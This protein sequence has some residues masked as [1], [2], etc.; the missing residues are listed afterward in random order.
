MGYFTGYIG[1]YHTA[2]SYGIYRFSLDTRN[3]GLSAPEPFLPVHGSKY[4]ALREDGL[5]ASIVQHEQGAGLF[6]TKLQDGTHEQ[7]ELLP[8]TGA[9]SLRHMPIPPI[10]TAV[11]FAAIGWLI[12][13][14]CSSIPSPSHLKQ[15][16]TRFCC[17]MTCFLSPVWSLTRSAC[18]Q[19]R[20][21]RRRGQSP[22]LPAVGRGTAYSAGRTKTCMLQRK[23]KIRS[24]VLGFMQALL[25]RNS[26]YRCS[27]HPAQAATKLR[28]SD[29]H[30]TSAFSMSRCAAQ[31]GSLYWHVLR[32]DCR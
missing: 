20:I 26:V 29:F 16:A 7:N 11:R 1:T 19:R 9:G 6:L 18:F 17:T 22:S 30:R 3:G 32:T 31:T 10:S 21:M 5:L 23:K 24:T 25:N 13:C 14:R 4:L 8:E 2:H 27:I 28:R 12:P 15:A